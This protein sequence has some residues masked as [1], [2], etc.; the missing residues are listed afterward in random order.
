[1]KNLKSLTIIILMIL[2]TMILCTKVEATTG[3]ITGETVRVRSEANTKSNILAQLDK[4]EKVEILEQ[5]EGWYKVTF[6]KKGEKITGYISESLVDLEKDNPQNEDNQVKEE[7]NQNSQENDSESNKQEESKEEIPA[8]E[9]PRTDGSSITIEEGKEYKINQTIKIKNLPSMS[10]AEKTE[11]NN[12]NIKAIE[13]INDWCK[14]EN[15]T[16]TGWLR[17]NTLKKSIEGSEINT[18]EPKDAEQKEEAK[19][20]ENTETPKEEN[21]TENVSNAK[22][23]KKLYVSTDSL[24]VRKENNTTS[25]IIDSLKKNDE[26][27]VIEELDGWY[28]IKVDGKIGYVSSKYVSTQKSKEATSRGAEIQRTEE[29]TE[30][31]EPETTSNTSSAK[32]SEVV[33]YAKQYI[34]YKYVSGGASPSTGFDCSGFTTY[35]YKQFGI[36]L[37]RTSRDQIKNG[38]AVERSNL[39]QGDLVLF[40]GESGSSIGH[41]G[42]YVGGGEFIHASNPKGGVKIT[43]LDSSYY[44]TRYVGARRVTD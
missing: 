13:V 23:I 19:N 2:T 10:S 22:V 16:E 29:V 32:G 34:G 12:T 24:K 30:I 20:E 26:V 5:S 25:E 8:Q 39:Q 43:A 27:S 44:N 18:E 3:K 4:N 15:E 37:N 35:V 9:E 31:K 33:S 41:V 17:I 38:T 28:K 36:K 1:M 14:I 11:L 7:D 21:K 42:I 40:R 6:T